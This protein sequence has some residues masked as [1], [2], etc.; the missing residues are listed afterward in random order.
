MPIAPGRP[1]IR[2]LRAGTLA[3]LLTLFAL[4]AASASGVA[5][6]RLE[7]RVLA[8]VPAP[9]FPASAT[10]GSDGTI[11]TGTFK[12]FSFPS[13]TGPSK[14]FAFSPHGH[15]LRTYTVTGQTRGA[16]DAVQVATMDRSGTLYLLDQD[17]ARIV[18]LNPV[19]GQQTAWATFRSLPACPSGAATGQ[20]SNGSGGNP[21]E[22]DFAAWGPDGSLYVTDYNQAL[23]WRVPPT[24]GAASVWLT[25]PRLNGIIVGPAGLQLMADG[26]TLLLSAGGGGT[27]PL[28]G[29]LYTLPIGA[30]GRPGVLHQLWE[31]GV[32]EAPDGLAIARSG[33]IYLALVGPTGNA[34]VEISSH[35]Q[36]IARVPADAAANSAMSVPFD[37]PGSVAFAGDSVIVTNG[38]SLLNDS[39]HWALLQITVGEPG[40]SPSLPP[41]A[42]APITYRLGV[43]PRRVVS[44]RRT[45]FR[46]TA[47]RVVGHTVRPIAGALVRFAGRVAHTGRRGRA[48]LAL[49]L[50]RR[51]TRFRAVL[52]LNGHRV[53]T[54]VIRTR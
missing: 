37:A 31:S 33:N 4:L 22:P 20:C 50:H 18:K 44:G 15:L 25:D 8:H 38:A 12:S 51:Q 34:V 30:D 41:A 42:R 36:L 9:G 47:T 7:V 1:L 2:H 48:R 23:I 49:I 17:P 46:F 35:G 54:A 28:T 6:A 45:I 10:V 53:A 14:V 40:L 52:L 39:G 27:D 29:K 24:G 19:T 43:N 11:F 5:Q 32:A 16:A 26:H 3:R 21:P 13:D